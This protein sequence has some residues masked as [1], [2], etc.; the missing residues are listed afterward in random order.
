MSLV[1][2]FF[3][4]QKTA[5]EVRISDWSSDVGSSDLNGLDH[6]QQRVVLETVFSDVG[7]VHDRLGGQQVE[8]TNNRFF[9]GV[10]ALHQGARRL[11]EGEVRSEERRVG[12]EGVS[13]CRLRW[14]PH[15]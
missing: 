9:V 1:L 3:F 10:H 15:H 11:A 7:D 8:A 13:T 12:K 14:S 4:K 6:V 5:Y 2:F